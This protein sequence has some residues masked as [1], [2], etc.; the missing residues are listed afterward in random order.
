MHRADILKYYKKGATATKTTAAPARSYALKCVYNKFCASVYA[1][2]IL[3]YSVYGSLVVCLKIT[4]CNITLCNIQK[5]NI[6]QLC[7]I[8][9]LR[10]GVQ[11]AVPR[12]A[13]VHHR[14]PI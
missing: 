7:V 10:Y 6:V 12:V 3:L 14:R 8:L 5:Y 13:R 11:S 9:T 4:R 2:H 1:L